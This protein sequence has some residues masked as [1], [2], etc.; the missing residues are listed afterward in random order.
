MM[1]KKAKSEDEYGDEFV[2]RLELI[3]GTGFLSPGGAAEVQAL[4]EK[5]DLGNCE[6]LDIGC[7]SGGVD[8]LL[9]EQ[10]GASKVVG[11]DVEQPLIDR[12]I[13]LAQEK[14]LQKNL[15]FILVDPGPLPFNDE[16]FDVVFSKDAIIHIPDKSSLYSD[17]YRV[18]KPGGRFIA[19]DWLKSGDGELKA[20][21]EFLDAS[22]FSAK[23]ETPA[24][25]TSLLEATGFME[26][27]VR[28]RTTWLCEETR[29][30][31]ELVTGSLK[32][33]AIELLGPDKYESWLR[34]RSSLLAA[35]ESKEL[36][37]SHLI[38]KKPRANG[39]PS[40]RNN[41]SA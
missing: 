26:V 16:S 13:K 3:Y 29:R 20:L 5:F 21:Q 35:L 2:A 14:D 41:A 34:V 10:H 27:Q 4:L 40:A 7:G 17:V 30:D 31:N 11:I 8:I 9:V 33:Q 37:P 39:T 19:S 25:S 6:V 12:A 22:F 24:T 23:M 38:A 32:K 28:D 36:R 18:L 1:N 15:E